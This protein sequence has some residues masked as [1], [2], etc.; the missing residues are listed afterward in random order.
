MKVQVLRVFRAVEIQSCRVSVIYK[1]SEFRI[2]VI[3]YRVYGLGP[4]KGRGSF[5][6]S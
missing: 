2:I 5:L 3:G 4:E 1:G 6:H